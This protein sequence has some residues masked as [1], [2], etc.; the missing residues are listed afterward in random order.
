MFSTAGVEATFVA[1]EDDDDNKI[2]VTV[3][4]MVAKVTVELSDNLNVEAVNG[5]L[6]DYSFAVNNFNLKSFMVQGAAPDYKDPNWDTDPS[7]DFDAAT[8]SYIPVVEKVDEVKSLTAHYVSEN[9]SKDKTREELTYVTVRAKFIPENVTVYNNGNDA[10]G[11]FKTVTPA[12]LS[13]T[14][15]RIFYSVTPSVALGTHFFYTETIADDFVT[16]KGGTKVP[17]PDGYCYWN[18]F[19]NKGTGN[20]GYEWDVVRNEFFRCTITR[21]AAIGNEVPDVVDPDTP[22]D[23]D[24]KITTNINILYWNTPVLAE[25]V[26]E[27]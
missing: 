11:G 3:Q 21:I 22:P 5:T 15:P 23:T 8:G 16:A 13:I 20:K 26:L 19:L 17:Y 27:P 25:Y 6:S 2:T 4:R 7:G 24:T 18:I 9:T 10:S 1:D 14:T 12:S